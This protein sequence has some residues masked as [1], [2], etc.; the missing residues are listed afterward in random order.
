[1]LNN[2]TNNTACCEVCG[3]NLDIVGRV[4]RCVPLPGKT[5]VPLE[6][7]TK[8][9]RHVYGKST[10]MYR[11]KEKWRLYMREYMRKRRRGKKGE[12]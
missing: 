11:D 7:V 9:L 3:A 8:N 5:E 4:H 10:H 2:M 1:M 6:K 12:G